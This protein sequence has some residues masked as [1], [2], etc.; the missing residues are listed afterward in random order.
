LLTDE[1]FRNEQRVGKSVVLVCLC[2]SAG[3][4]ECAVAVGVLKQ[5]LF[6]VKD[7]VF[8]VA[9]CSCFSLGV[10]IFIFSVKGNGDAAPDIVF[11][12]VSTVLEQ[13]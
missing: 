9:C 8:S 4:E 6:H 3:N 12:L 1:F 10:F 11:C 5:I 7:L 13:I 2:L